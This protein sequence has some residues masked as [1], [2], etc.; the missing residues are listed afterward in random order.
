[1]SKSNAFES[2]ILKLIFNAT[3]IADLA[4]DDQTSPATTITVALHTADPAEGGT[5]ATNEATYTGY[6][7]QTVARTTGGWTESSGSVSPVAQISF[8]EATGGSETIT[9]FSV[10]S[11]VSDNLLYSGT[12]TP[13]IV[14]STGVTP[15]L[16]TTSTITED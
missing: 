12:V 15:I 7:R 10:G 13:N 14:V 16:K 8:P 2:A 11:G 4:D 3:P 1:M 9:H 5:M 6:A